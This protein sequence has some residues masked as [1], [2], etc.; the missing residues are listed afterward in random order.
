MLKRLD[1]I[2]GDTGL[3][4][5]S[6]ARELIRSGA[7]TVDGA[8][9]ASPELRVDPDR[10]VIAVDGTPLRTDAARYLVMD[11]PAGVVCAR[12]D[13]DHCT[14]L[15]L[16]PREYRRMGVLPVGRLDIDTTGLLLLTNDGDFAH[17]VISPRSGTSKLY[18]AETDAP[19][20]Q[21]DTAAF[22]EGLT[23][24]DGL[25][26]MPALLR[27]GEGSTCFVTVREGKYHQV[28]RML[29]S[30]GKRVLSLRRLSIGGLEL[31]PGLGPGGFRELS[32][33][34]IFAVL[35]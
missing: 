19:V 23:L 12:E 33:S 27:A 17:R 7:V 5:R 29:A 15:D 10:Q 21:S 16:L 9:A 35:G 22:A 30:R 3:Y 1:K 8:A 26:C 2:I 28:K 34:E 32:Q 6:R 11:K 24:A 20:T 14:V 13:R 25:R 4:S 18:R 31:D